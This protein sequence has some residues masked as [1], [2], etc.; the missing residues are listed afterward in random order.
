MYGVVSLLCRWYL[1]YGEGARLENER[2]AHILIMLVRQIHQHR[3]HPHSTVAH[4]RIG[5]D[6][7]AVGGVRKVDLGTSEVKTLVS[8][9][10]LLELLFHGL[11][12]L[13]WL[14][15]IY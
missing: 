10:L 11:V 5:R 1:S 9:I 15:H 3:A 2:D 12:I 14:R 6:M 13:R 8:S 7:A 4:L